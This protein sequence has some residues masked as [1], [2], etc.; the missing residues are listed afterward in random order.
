MC[1]Y[2]AFSDE[3]GEYKKDMHEKFI[4]SSPYYVRATFLMLASDWKKLNVRFREIKQRFKLPLE[5]EIKWSYLWQ[6]KKYKRDGRNIQ[7][8]KPFYFL[9]NR[10]Y[11]HVIDFVDSSLELLS[12]LSYVKIIITVTSNSHCPRINENDIYKMHIQDNMQR[13]EMELQDQEDNLCVLFIDSISEKKNKFLRDVY[14]DMCQKGDFIQNYS[15]IKDSLNLEYS[16]HSV[17]IQLGDYVAGSFGGF[18]K[19]YEESKKIFNNKIKPYLRTGSN[20]EI[21]GFG[22]MEV[23]KNDEVRTHIE[24][25]LYA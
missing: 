18:L 21:L 1:I 11:N 19:G 5:E 23:P 9:K 14:F 6:L 25:K 22:I 12:D 15:H 24:E 7:E 8:N 3:N 20:K 16:H 4:K 10:D 2:F 17:G 13:I